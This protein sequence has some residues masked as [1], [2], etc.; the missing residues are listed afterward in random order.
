MPRKRSW[1]GRAERDVYKVDRALGDAAAYQRGGAPGLAK[2]LARRRVRRF[3][4]RKTH[5]WL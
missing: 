1:L 4:G 2:R 5:G 3:V